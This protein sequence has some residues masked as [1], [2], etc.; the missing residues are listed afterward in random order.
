MSDELP[1]T[2]ASPL[3]RAQPDRARSFGSVAEAYDRGRPAYPS[4]AVAWL[5]G[6]EAKVVLELGAGTG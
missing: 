2:P 4:E 6:G 3:E 5:A 1:A